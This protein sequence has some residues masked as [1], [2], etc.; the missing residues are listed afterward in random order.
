MAPTC[1]GKDAQAIGD[2]TSAFGVSANATGQGATA[3]GSNASAVDRATALGAFAS[4]TGE[5]SVAVGRQANATGISSLAIGEE[6]QALG[7]RSFA[8]GVQANAAQNDTLAL[9]SGATAN[10][11]RSAALGQGVSTTRENQIALGSA[12]AQVT[13]ANLANTTSVSGQDTSSFGAV[14]ANGDGTLIRSGIG[15]GLQVEVDQSTGD[16]NLSVNTGNGIT[17]GDGGVEINTGKQHLHQQL[18][19]PQCRQHNS[20]CW[21]GHS[22]RW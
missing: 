6:A 19:C 7:D 21:N 9:G 13:I 17:I 2:D 5:N 14:M 4:A 15:K 18:R 20:G 16:L 10:Y 22:R 3:V 12:S 1:F 11:S 8:F